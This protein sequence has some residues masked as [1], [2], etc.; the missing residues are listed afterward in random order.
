LVLF[1]VLLVLFFVDSGFPAYF[2]DA[3]MPLSRH[4]VLPRSLDPD[5][6]DRQGFWHWQLFFPAAGQEQHSKGDQLKTELLEH[7]Y[8][9]GLQGRSRLS[10]MV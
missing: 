4:G 10:H 5:R 6:G 1:L 9:A 8:L 2:V 7:Q 3:V